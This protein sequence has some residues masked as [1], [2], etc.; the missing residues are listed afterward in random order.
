MQVERC[1]HIGTWRTRH[2]FRLD[3]G[4]RR[5]GSTPIEWFVAG[6]R[7]FI[8]TAAA[9][10]HREGRWTLAMPTIGTGGGKA[11]H[12]GIARDLVPALIEELHRHG[13][14]VDLVLVCGD[15]KWFA[16]AQM[17]RARVADAFRLSDAR[18]AAAANLAA[19]FDQELR[20]VV[21]VGAG[22]SIGAG[23]PGWTKLLSDLVPEA[24]RPALE[25]LARRD[26]LAAA[27]VVKNRLGSEEALAKR[28]KDRLVPSSGAHSPGLGHMLLAALPAEGYVTTNFDSLLE[29]ALVCA[30]KPTIVL[31]RQQP[32]AGCRWV[33]KLHGT[34]G[35]DTL[36]LTRSNF[37]RFDASSRSLLSLVEASLLLREL[38]VVGFSFTDPNFLRAVDGVR[39]TLER[40]GV[41]RPLFTGLVV[42]EE[43][44]LRKDLWPHEV[45]VD[46]GPP[47]AGGDRDQLIFLDRVNAL[48]SSHEHFLDARFEVLLSDADK[49]LAT[50]LR[51]LQVPARGHGALRRALASYGGKK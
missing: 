51:A 21:F 2:L 13:D 25:D 50:A 36:I 14:D 12:A 30:G 37:L 40:A 9:D 49:N 31:P 35:D 38:V 48:V 43:P 20:P 39:Q 28:V 44:P 16:A 8:E 6:A 11:D 27:E 22:V 42:D 4:G 5:D 15:A 10:R 18:E 3:T 29:E 17:A 33:L 26:P 7:S 46:F 1:A 41:Q 32:Q 34:V 47:Q 19:T 23:L 24:V 45:F